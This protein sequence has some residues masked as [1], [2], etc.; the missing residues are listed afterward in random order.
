M[1]SLLVQ[2]KCL[3]VNLKIEPMTTYPEIEN[4]DFI[5]SNNCNA[6]NYDLDP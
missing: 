2:N 6:I 4:F 3:I 5:F 1:H